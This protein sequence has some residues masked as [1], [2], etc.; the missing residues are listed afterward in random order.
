MLGTCR[1]A[2]YGLEKENFPGEAVWVFVRSNES[3]YGR[4][5]GVTGGDGGKAL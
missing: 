3:F 5:A 1:F 2:Q 4:S